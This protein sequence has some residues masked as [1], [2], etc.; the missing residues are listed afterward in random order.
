MASTRSCLF[1]GFLFLVNSVAS[2]AALPRRFGTVLS[3]SSTTTEPLSPTSHTHSVNDRRDFPSGF[4]FG[5]ASSAYQ[6]E[7]AASDGGRSQS[8]WDNFTHTFP[9]KIDDG[10]NGDMA[11]N[12]YHRYQED[13]GMMKNLSLDAYRFSISWSRVIPKGIINRGVN[14][15]GI[16]YYNNLI[17]ELLHNGIEPFVTLFH[18][19]LPQTLEDEYGG[20]LSPQIVDDFRDYAELCFMEFGDRVKYWITLN[21][22]WSFSNG[23][24]ATGTL[25][26]G[27]CSS[28]QQNNCTGGDASLEPYLVTHHQLLAHAAAV[29]LYKN[30]YQAAQEGKIGITLVTLWTEPFSNSTEDN[31]AAERA[32]D[33]M[34]GWF[35]DPLTSGNYPDSMRSRV[36][37]RLPKFS[38]EQSRRVNGSFDFLGL[39][40]YTANY[41]AD[42]TNSDNGLYMSYTT[43]SGVNLTSER[44][45]VYIGDETGSDWLFVYPSGI[46]DLLVYINGKYN[47]PVIYITENGVSEK[48]NDTIPL[49]EALED[50]Q[51]VNYHSSH[52]SCVQQAIQ[53]GV[54]VMG[55]FVWSLMDNFEWNAGYTV[56]FGISYID[57]NNG[58]KRYPKAS[59]QWFKYFLQ[60]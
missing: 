18:W 6:F 4:V 13:V 20:F 55:Y 22:P 39:N 10:S 36:G 47:S 15:E 57:Y 27:R 3:D 32:L 9:D 49:E 28:W 41:A 21:E 25:A 14:R 52:L 51:R 30:K 37:S 38:E 23:G 59:Y 29:N 31:D 1:L 8:I 2:I 16:E 12:S 17:N 26:P 54:N 53:D 24:Y 48:R 44:N 34:F 45:G 19:D 50:T 7:G 58:L 33:F 43:D 56:R 42:L 11:I 46:H 5:A 35:M 60:K 40:Y